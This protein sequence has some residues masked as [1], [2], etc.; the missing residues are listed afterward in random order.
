MSILK[1]E[2]VRLRVLT[3]PGTIRRYLASH[4]TPRL[5]LGCG[6]QVVD[7]WLNADMFKANADIYLNAKQ[8]FPFKDNA[9]ATVYSEHML[10]HI[11]VDKVP[12]LLREVHRILHKGGL[13]RVTVPDL[14]VYIQRYLN[15][16]EEFF[17]PIKEKFREKMAEKPNKYWLVRTN[18]GVVVSRAVHRFYHHHWM[19]DFETLRSC[20]DEVGFTQ[21]TKQQFRNSID[22]VA[23]NM[24]RESRAAESLYVDA[25]K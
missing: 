23:G 2:L 19:Y 11:K 21:V 9:F 8:L 25:I 24:D 13:F 5:H 18:G 1:G 6:S 10:E 22:P 14:D 7:G 12:Q 17:G 16:D 15:Q 20:L 4:E 3:R